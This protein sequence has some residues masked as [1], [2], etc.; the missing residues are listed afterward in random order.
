MHYSLKDPLND[1]YQPLLHLFKEK[2]S[3]LSSFQQDKRKMLKFKAKGV[4]GSM[5]ATRPRGSMKRQTRV[6]KC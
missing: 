5:A 6:I 3:A 4:C 2:I 1:L